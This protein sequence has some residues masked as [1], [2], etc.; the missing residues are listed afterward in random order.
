MIRGEE[1]LVIGI[2]L[3]IMIVIMY[4]SYRRLKSFDKRIVRIL[5]TLVIFILTFI[6]QILLTGYGL[7]NNEGLE[8]MGKGLIV[9]VLIIPLTIMVAEAILMPLYTYLINKYNKGE[10]TRNKFTLY[11]LIILLL[12]DIS[13]LLF[14]I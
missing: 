3:I 2:Y 12:N 8:E 14:Y 9:L 4:I 6:M 13:V 1:M 11:I 7:I 10:I 5:I